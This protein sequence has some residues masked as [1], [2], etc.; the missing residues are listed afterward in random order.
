MFIDRSGFGNEVVRET[1]QVHLA[2]LLESIDA[3][4]GIPPAPEPERYRRVVDRLIGDL[5][6]DAQ[7]GES[8]SVEYSD[9]D[10]NGRARRLTLSFKLLKGVHGYSG[11]IALQSSSEA[12]NLFLNA[13]DLDI[14]SEQIANEAVVQFHWN[15]GISTRPAS[16]PKPPRADLFYTSRISSASSD[17]PSVTSVKFASRGRLPEGVASPSCPPSGELFPSRVSPNGD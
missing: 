16:E 11:E 7:R 9:F 12:I 13:L 6:N 3:A 14:E 5:L 1:V 8:F 4:S 10:S 15:A 2:P 17:R